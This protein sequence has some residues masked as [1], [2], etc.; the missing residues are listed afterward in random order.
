[1]VYSPNVVVADWVITCIF[2]LVFMVVS[3]SLKNISAVISSAIMCSGNSWKLFWQASAAVA[4]YACMLISSNSG[5]LLLNSI[6]PPLLPS[7]YN[8]HVSDSVKQDSEKSFTAF[9]ELA[10]T[11]NFGRTAKTKAKMSRK[12]IP[13]MMNM[14]IC[15]LR[16]IVYTN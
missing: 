2:C 14:V 8:K 11:L 7:V 1:V 6:F 12:T 5:R 4:K 10:V 16:F 3:F 13:T 9:F 15:A